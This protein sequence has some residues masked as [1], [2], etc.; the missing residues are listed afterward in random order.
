MSDDANALH[1]WAVQRPRTNVIDPPMAD[2]LGIKTGTPTEDN[3][4]SSGTKDDT[5][6]DE[7]TARLE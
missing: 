2:L 1:Q 4:E 6:N 3:S 7:H 5:S